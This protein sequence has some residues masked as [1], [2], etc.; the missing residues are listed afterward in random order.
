MEKEVQHQDAAGG[1]S[2]DPQGDADIMSGYDQFEV[3]RGDFFPDDETGD[4]Q[5]HDDDHA[6][7]SGDPEASGAAPPA[8]PDESGTTGEA[9]QQGGEAAPGEKPLQQSGDTAAQKRFRHTSHEEAE[10]S[11]ANLLSRTTRTEQENARLRQQLKEI[12]EAKIKQRRDEEA[13][14]QREDF[15]RQ[16]YEEAAKAVDELDQDD[17]EYHSRTARIWADVHQAVDSFEPEVKEPEGDA[18]RPRIS[19]FKKTGQPADDPDGSQESVAD[20]AQEGAP[21]EGESQQDA[22]AEAQESPGMTRDQVFEVIDSRLSEK[23]PGFD[24]ED[25]AFI[26]FCSRAPEA[27]EN[28][29]P[30]SI[31]QQVD[32]AIDA[33]RKHYDAKNREVLQRS[34]QPMDRGSRAAGGGR[35]ASSEETQESFGD[36]VEAAVSQHRL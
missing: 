22:G 11:Y 17:P 6:D 36:I 31:E 3:Y 13:R 2:T 10:K 27:D 12:E 28:G 9:A 19:D 8:A 1:E 20:P 35:Q 25:P 18:S 34:A 29:N 33:T 23:N 15:V 5:G 14:R 30:L 4:A 16:K 24:K 26:G 21:P 7:H 32:Y